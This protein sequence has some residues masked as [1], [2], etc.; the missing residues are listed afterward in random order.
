MKRMVSSLAGAC[1]VALA[2]APAASA[3]TYYLSGNYTS[4]SGSLPN[5][6]AFWAQVETADTL[7]LEFPGGSG[8]A[9]PYVFLVTG[10]Y[11]EFGDPVSG[12][13]YT[14][15]LT[16]NDASYVFE[17]SSELAVGFDGFT[18]QTNLSVSDP[19]TPLSIPD[20]TPVSSVRFLPRGS[21]NFI[22]AYVGQ[23]TFVGLEIISGSPNE[24]PGP[25]PAS[26]IPTP[27][28]AAPEPATWL[29]MI[30]GVGLT[31]AAFRQ[32]RASLDKP[33]R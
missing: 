9:D 12:P 31:G 23:V 7:A 14:L 26:Q 32:R 15:E 5:E 2:W 25:P 8:S 13:N 33:I 6:G 3:A 24:N 22:N 17:T 18:A 21:Y 10:G 27:T 19:T 4:K 1:L 29:M 16:P 28:L 30:L 20:W 11:A